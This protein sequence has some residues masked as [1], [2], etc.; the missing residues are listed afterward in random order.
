MHNID[1]L[2]KFKNYRRV[3]NPESYKYIKA[4]A[5]AK[6]NNIFRRQYYE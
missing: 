3:F 4:K 6:I 1:N 5:K 2:K